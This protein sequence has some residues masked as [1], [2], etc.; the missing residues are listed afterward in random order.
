MTWS[1]AVSVLYALIAMLFPILAEA[2]IVSF[3]LL[4]LLPAVVWEYRRSRRV[5]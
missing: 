2:L 5:P 3:I 4:L 1:F